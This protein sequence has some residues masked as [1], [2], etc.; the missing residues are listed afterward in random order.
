MA[1]HELV[2]EGFQ[3]GQVGSSAMPHKMNTRSCERVNGFAVILR[4]LRVDGRRAGRRPVERGRRLLLGGAPG[5]AAGRVLRPRRAAR[6]VPDRAGRASAPSRPSSTRELDRYLPFLA[7]TK[8]LMAAVRA[9]VGRETAHEVIKE[10]AVAVALAM[11]EKG[12]DAQ[13]PVRRG[14]PPTRGCGLAGGRVGRAAGRAAVLHRRGRGSRWPRWSP[15]C[16]TSSSPTR[17]RRPTDPN[18]SSDLPSGAGLSSAGSLR[19]CPSDLV[20]DKQAPGQPVERWVLV[21]WPG[22]PAFGFGHSAT[23]WSRKSS[24]SP[25][26]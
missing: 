1:G 8:V 2:T 18:P 20:A 25:V 11:R 10:H 13:R 5:R 14:W 21:Y 22:A 23:T 9:G 17:T 4:G 26:S 15:R 7:T 16:R 19:A 24:T 6:D 3:P 12:A